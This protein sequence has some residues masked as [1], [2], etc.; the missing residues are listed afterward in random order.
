MKNIFFNEGISLF[1]SKM[2]PYVIFTS[3][4]AIAYQFILSHAPKIYS[5]S[6]LIPLI[7][8]IIIGKFFFESRAV[9]ALN[10][11]YIYTK[12]IITMKLIFKGKV[13]T[14][15]VGMIINIISFIPIIGLIFGF[16]VSLFSPVI[17]EQYYLNVI[18]DGKFHFETDNVLIAIKQHF[19]FC[20]RYFLFSMISVLALVGIVFLSIINQK[21]III[22]VLC[23]GLID[24]YISAVKY[25]YFMNV[26]TINKEKE[27]LENPEF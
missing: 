21:F 12:Q 5:I 4:L 1:V 22:L 2:I 25:V 3:I 23:A 10:G 16:C 6:V 18:K 24:I 9:N 14:F 15:L 11:Q 26:K 27:I 17:F 19:S 8:I 7:F 13:N 20:L